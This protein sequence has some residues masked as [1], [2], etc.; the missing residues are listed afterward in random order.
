MHIFDKNCL[1]ILKKAVNMLF[2]Q[3]FFNG[4]KLHVYGK[5]SKKYFN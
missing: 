5:V 4:N 3:G 1:L 2:V